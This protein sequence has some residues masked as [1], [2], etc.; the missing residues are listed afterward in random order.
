METDAVVTIPVEQSPAVRAAWCPICHCEADPFLELEA[1]AAELNFRRA[2]FA[3]RLGDELT[4]A[5][6]R[7]LTEVVRGVPAPI[8]RC[9]LC[10]T[11]I[12]RESS[13]ENP[14]EDDHYD[15][16]TLWRL[17]R[18]HRT[19]FRTKWNDYRPLLPAGARVLEI[20][21]YVGGFLATAAEW[22]WTPVGLDVG[23]DTTQFTQSLGL[24]TT[25]SSME[26]YEPPSNRFD[27]VFFWN[28]FEQLADPSRALETASN[29]V[30]PDGVVVI[31]V[32]DA[33]F[34]VRYRERAQRLNGYNCLLGFPH[35]FG[36]TP[37]SLQRMAKSA[38]LRLFQMLR[39]PVI[40]PLR[41]Q[42]MEWARVEE[43]RLCGAEAGWG[44]MELT[45]VRSN[46][47]IALSF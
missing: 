3:A 44:W 38:S 46:E 5:P 4:H 24:N 36:F 47:A 19:A 40:R 37:A 31:R 27:G 22:G 43:Q 35:L 42:M 6:L 41:G 17:F 34:Y 1:I 23:I 25:Q 16:E 21:S 11:L 32:P 20:G 29:L 9:P 13:S 18:D 26:G 14:Y 39:R 2:F 30:K 45:F 33:G 12:R 8:D 15:D 7:D 10:G 28:C